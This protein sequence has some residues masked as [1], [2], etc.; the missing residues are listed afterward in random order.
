MKA[1]L[2]IEGDFQSLER[3][4]YEKGRDENHMRKAETNVPNAGMHHLQKGENRIV[5]GACQFALILTLATLLVSVTLIKR[6]AAEPACAPT[7]ASG[8]GPFYRPNAPERHKTGRGL[9]VRG[10]VRSGRD[11]KALGGASLEWWQ[12][13]RQGEYDD[14]HRATTRT[15]DGTYR[16]E[17]DFPTGYS[18]RPSHIHVKVFAPGHRPLT[19]QIYPK[20]G[21]KEIVFDFVLTQE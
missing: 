11:C 20:A 6:A 4:G 2:R 21:E 7:P 17:T 5:S 9:L 12:A 16:Y 10:V 15:E 13:N 3:G 14:Q 18:N 19:T 8:E 1:D